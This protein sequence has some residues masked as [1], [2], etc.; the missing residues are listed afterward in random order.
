MI[1]IIGNVPKEIL[2]F[3]KRIVVSYGGAIYSMLPFKLY[4][5][6]G[7]AYIN[8]EGNALPYIFLPYKIGFNESP[9]LRITYR[10]NKE[11]LELLKKGRPLTWV[12]CGDANI[13]TT[14][15]SDEVNVKFLKDMGNGFSGI[16]VQGLL[17]KTKA[18]YLLI[19]P[20]S[21]KVVEAIKQF[22][23]I[24]MNEEEARFFDLS[25]FTDSKILIT[26]GKR[27]AKLITKNNELEVKGVKVKENH[28]VGA[29]SVFLSTF[30]I[31]KLKGSTDLK[32]LLVANAFAATFV[33]K[34][35]LEKKRIAEILSSQL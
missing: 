23:I 17:R 7:K 9:V 6:E 10:R 5:V 16:D 15:F 26:R 28:P 21:K 11:E 2:D 25:E 34:G 8:A 29:G 32:A 13:I 18:T 14:L 22:K 31:E 33:E 27:G 19:K 12:K 30:F 3:K 4:S 20:P 24:K 1:N 35:K